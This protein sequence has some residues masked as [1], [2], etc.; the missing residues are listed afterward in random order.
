MDD[1]G[2][3]LMYLVIGIVMLIAMNIG[4]YIIGS[5]LA[6]DFNIDH[7]RIFSN[8]ETKGLIIRMILIAE[9]LLIISAFFTTN[10]ND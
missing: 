5:F 3:F 10:S 1:F 2:D 4:F 7:W 8:T 6:W 9:T